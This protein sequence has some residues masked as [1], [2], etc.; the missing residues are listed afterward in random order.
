MTKIW[1][2]KSMFA[3][4]LVAFAIPWVAWSAFQILDLETVGP[5]SDDNR[6]GTMLATILLYSGGA[7][8][9][10]GLVATY[11][12]GGKKQL[13][14]LLRSL[15]IV[16]VET[17]WWLYALFLPLCYSTLGLVTFAI[18]HGG[19]GSFEI[20][21]LLLYV[22]P[23]VLLALTT[24]PIGEEFGWRGFLLPKLLQQYTP[25]AA[26]VLLGVIWSLWHLPLYIDEVFG[27]LAQGLLFTFMVIAFSILMT[28]LFL[29]SRKSLLL[30]IVFHWT[31]NISPQIIRGMFPDIPNPDNAL[32]NDFQTGLYQLAPIILTAAIA[33]AWT[34]KAWFRNVQHL[35]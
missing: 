25:F 31:I 30:I 7:C 20:S 27:T 3:F 17:R 21:G 14:E 15:L 8:S 13:V 24:G 33:I 28:H 10:G 35:E 4:F 11:V 12:D 29:H 16:N 9:I 34:G 19:L 23:I 32:V 2:E 22:S 26:S 1:L 5:W 6:T 18:I